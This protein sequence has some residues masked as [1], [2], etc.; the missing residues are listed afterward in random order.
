M[1]AKRALLVGCNYPGT[2]NALN[3]CVNDVKA[4][5]A[6]L[7]TY[8][9]FSPSDLTTMIDTDP[10][11]VKPTGK[12]I[13]AGLKKLVDMSEPGDVLFFH[14]SGHGTQVPSEADNEEED[15]KD[16]AICPTDLN[17][18]CDDDL[19]E[20]FLNLKPGVK[21]T[22]VADCCHSGSMLDQPIVA[23]SGPKEGTKCVDTSGLSMKEID[24]GDQV[25]H[26]DES[27]EVVQAHRAINKKQLKAALMEKLGKKGEKMK[28]GGVKRALREL[29]GND[30][31]NNARGL[32]SWF[33]G[34]VNSMAQGYLQSQGLGGLASALG[35]MGL[36][37]GGGSTIA[38]GGGDEPQLNVTVPTG[39][40]PPPEKQLHGDNYVL[41]T[42]C[43][44]HET[45][46]D[47]CPSGDPTKAFGALTNSL[48]T[49]VKAHFQNYPNEPISNRNLVAATRSLMAKSRYAQN[50][51]L[52]CTGPAADDFFIVTPQN[53]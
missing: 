1:P 23:I 11:S 10:S 47:A 46:A 34:A 36:G 22:M 32:L 31:S 42:G 12:N 3:G 16:E 25:I 14:F 45:S 19:R 27:E 39:V 52:E 50:P 4:M 35:G 24:L 48:T 18:I 20:I 53:K 44:S 2:G 21:F 28:K 26:V 17:V 49:V 33:S 41:I 9:G 40:K 38:T 30:A 13:K 15:S 43:Q 37:G 8:Y 29:H 5:T 6:M 51:C 7:T